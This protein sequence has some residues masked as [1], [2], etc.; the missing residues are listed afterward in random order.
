MPGFS[1]LFLSHLRTGLEPFSPQPHH[2]LSD[3]LA[4]SCLSNFQAQASKTGGPFKCD[5]AVA[6]RDIVPG[7]HLYICTSFHA[8]ETLDFWGCKG[9]GRTSKTWRY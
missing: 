8:T 2:F 6:L 5:P 4:F 3:A 9:N 1:E 7:H